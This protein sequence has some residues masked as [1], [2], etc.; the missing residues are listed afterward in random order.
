MLKHGI[1]GLLNYGAMTGYDIMLVFKDS[2]QFFWQAQTSQIYRELQ[3]L[4]KK[5]WVADESVAQSGKPDKKLFHITDDGKAELRRWLSDGN[6][7][8][9]ERSPVLMKTFFRGELSPSENLEA[10]KSL[11]AECMGYIENL[12]NAPINA[13]KHGANVPDEASASLYWQ[14]TIDYGMMYYKMYIEWVDSCIKKLEEVC[15][16]EN[17]AD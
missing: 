16:Y 13:K 15:S 10:F 2:L 5:G 6:E 8:F 3:A 9:P 4:K 14:M 7:K 1:L 11:R 17:T 12:K